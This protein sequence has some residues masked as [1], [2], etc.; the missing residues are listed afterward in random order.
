MIKVIFMDFDG[1]VSDVRESVVRSLVRVLDEFGYEYDHNLIMDLI[2]SKM[3]VILR[4]LGI[5]ERHLVK[6]R[7]KFYKY[8]RG[9]VLSGGTKPCVSL[10][11]LWELSKE[12]PLVVV[13]NANTRFI[14]ASIKQLGI[15][16]LFLGVYGAENFYTKDVMLRRLFKKYKISPR[17]AMYVGDRFSD[18]DYAR[19]AGCVAVAIHNKCSWSD[20]NAIKRE[21]PNFLIKDFRELK[22]LVEELNGD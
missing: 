9:A 18:I 6:V 21:K 8:L 13:S 2:G 7:K 4:G 12:Y 14:R 17:E 3:Q 10:K 19:D 1:T 15:K 20:L 5:D 16:G 22:R 11:P